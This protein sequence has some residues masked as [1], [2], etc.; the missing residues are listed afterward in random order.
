MPRREG[1]Q[2]GVSATEKM[3]HRQN[4]G[5]VPMERSSASVGSGLFRC[6][7]GF[8]DMGLNPQRVPIHQEVA[9]KSSLARFPRSAERKSRAKCSMTAVSMGSATIQARFGETTYPVRRFILDPAPIVWREGG[10]AGSDVRDSAIVYQLPPSRCPPRTPHFAFPP[11]S[12]A[13]NIAPGAPIPAA[14]PLGYPNECQ[15]KAS[16]DAEGVI[17]SPSWL[18]WRY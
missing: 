13:T 7:S 1:P 14:P 16:P 3:G 17:F 8:A 9:A 12:H 18:D 6:R 10:P 4:H 11:R 15:S 5:D 2:R